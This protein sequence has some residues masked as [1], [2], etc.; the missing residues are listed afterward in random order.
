[1]TRKIKI[2]N[3]IIKRRS[4]KE[5]KRLV[6]FKSKRIFYLIVCEG[7]KT[8]PNYFSSLKKSLPKGVLELTQI[9][10]DGTGKNTLS[11]IEE[12]KK[13]RKGYEEKYLRKIDKVWAVFDKDSFPARNFNNAIIKG[14]HSKPKIH[15]AWTNEA[16]ELWYLLHFNYYNTGLSRHQ[17]QRLLEK[18]ITK[19]SGKN[20]YKYKKNS[21]EMYALLNL[22]GSQEFAISNAEKLEKLYNDNSFSNHNPSTKV[23]LLIKEL[24]ELTEEYATQHQ[25]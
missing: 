7:E 19:A 5:K 14:E 17:Y 10:I 8:E 9:D 23:H 20:E 6:G 22:Y 12:A 13:L 15:C 24:K 25:I 16:F 3:A 11:I 21:T 1:M 18:E 2:D 4:R